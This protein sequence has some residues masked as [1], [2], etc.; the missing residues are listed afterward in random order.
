[1][2]MKDFSKLAGPM[3][4]VEYAS[5]LADMAS[6]RKYDCDLAYLW[7]T[8]LWI[9]ITAGNSVCRIV[10]EDM[11][12]SG[13]YC[14]VV[15]EGLR[16]MK[17]SGLHSAVTSRGTMTLAVPL[18]PCFR[19]S[20]PPLLPRP[21]LSSFQAAVK[22]DVSLS[23]KYRYDALCWIPCKITREVWYDLAAS[24]TTIYSPKVGVTPPRINVAFFSESK[25][26]PV[27]LDKNCILFSTSDG[28]NCGLIIFD[29]HGNRVRS[30]MVGR[31][32]AARRH[33]GALRNACIE[34]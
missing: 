7:N 13:D 8:H 30:H 21:A 32:T 26:C 31:S 9:E 12:P 15:R 27:A 20:Q 3:G 6:S 19:S 10:Y 23:V 2:R 16:A 28:R 33:F 24:G 11:E 4:L 17:K 18:R 25:Q 14:S 22:F 1:M 29:V 5:V 34:F